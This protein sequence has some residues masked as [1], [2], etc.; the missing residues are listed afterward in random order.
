MH[1]K[2][3]KA[4]SAQMAVEAFRACFLGRCKLGSWEVETER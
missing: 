1:P 2:R 4:N 3:Q